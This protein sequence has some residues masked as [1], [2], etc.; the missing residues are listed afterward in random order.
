MVITNDGCDSE[1][2]MYIFI[3]SAHDISFYIHSQ[4]EHPLPI[5][6]I[7]ASY[8]ALLKSLLDDCQRLW[9]SLIEANARVVGLGVGTSLLARRPF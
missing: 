6:E 4:C 3:M 8:A 2:L 1:L 7:L 9:E 5:I